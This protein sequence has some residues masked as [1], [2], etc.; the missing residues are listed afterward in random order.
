MEINLL[1]VPLFYGCDNPGVENGP[2]TLRENNLLNIFEANNHKIYDLGNLYVQSIDVNEKYKDNDK[3]KYLSPIIE[4]NNNLAHWVYCSL[5]SN[6][7]PLIIG[8]DHSLGL[9]T[10]AGS[11]KYFGDDFGVV[12]VDAHGD[13]NTLESSPSGN[14]HGMPLA[15]SMGI[16]HDSLTNVYFKGRKVN[17]NKVFILCAR[18]LDEG[19]LK[20]IKELGLN[21]WTSSTIKELGIEKVVDMLLNTINKLNI[22]NIH[23]SFDIDC[24]D[25]SLI[26]GT[27]TP[28]EEGMD[29]REAKYIINKLFNTKKVKAMDFVEFNPEIE[30]DTTL[31]NCLELLKCIS[32][33]IN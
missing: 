14:I 30:Y 16:G 19:E 21:V 26:P 17:P 10:L 33:C 12:W 8:G 31:K 27:G 6:N 23:L 3:L 7:F 20:L 5:K 4:V 22:N 11:S 28:V 13:I 29:L 24:T 32:E 2:N 9:G 1:G 18:D 15:A 25:P